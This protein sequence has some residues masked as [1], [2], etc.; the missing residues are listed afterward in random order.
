M[1]TIKQS[2]FVH[3]FFPSPQTVSSSAVC[4]CKFHE[5]LTNYLI[6]NVQ[7]ILQRGRVLIKIGAKPAQ[8][9]RE[10]TGR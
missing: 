5:D 10:S 7:A 2:L 1:I 3:P 6:F 8:T 9:N 4:L